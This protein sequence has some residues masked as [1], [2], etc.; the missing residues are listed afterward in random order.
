M[1]AVADAGSDVLRMEKR[2]LAEAVNLFLK[3]AFLVK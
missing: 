3:L 1:V 2:L